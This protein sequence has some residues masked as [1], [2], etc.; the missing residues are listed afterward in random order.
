MKRI[1]RL[2]TLASAL[3]FSASML[4][5]AGMPFQANP[6][7]A[8]II[9]NSTSYTVIDMLANDVYAFDCGLDALEVTILTNGTK[10]IARVR[11]ADKK[12]EYR[13]RPNFI[14]ADQVEY[15][16][17]CPAS[18]KTASATIYINI[19]DKPDAISDAEC[20]VDPV[21]IEFKIG[22]LDKT[23]YN[24][25][26]I[27]P[28]SPIITGDIDNDGEIEI[29]VFKANTSIGSNSQIS[30]FGFRQSTQKLYLK[31][32]IPFDYSGNYPYGNIAIAKITGGTANLKTTASVFLV[33]PTTNILYRYDLNVNGA[34]NLV[35]SETWHTQYT[36]NSIYRQATPFI[37]DI[38]GNGRQQ[39]VIIDKIFDANTGT[40]LA[41]ARN[42]TTPLIPDSGESSYSF[43]RYGHNPF[44]SSVVVADIDNDGKMEIIGGDC[45]YEVNIDYNTPSNNY[46]K[47]LR[48]ANKTGH[49][50]I[51]DGGTAL[52]DFDGDGYLD[53]VVASPMQF[54][55]YG[56]RDGSPNGSV[57]VYNPRTGAVMHTN[58]INN[59]PK[60]SNPLY[61]FGPSRPF[62][63]DLDG[64]GIP[65]FAI[66]GEATLRAY[67]LNGTTLS[68]MWDLP[69]TDRSAS[70]TLS[71]FDF[72]QDGRAKLIYRDEDNLRI[73]DGRIKDENGVTIT[74]ANRVLA[75]FPGV[76]SATT[77]EYPIVADVN[78]D[79]AAEIIAVGS[80]V[81]F[82]TGTTWDHKGS[83]QVY[84]AAGE[85]KWAPARSVW[86]QLAY[87]PLYVNDDLTIPA[88]P[89]S[90]ATEFYSPDGTIDRPFNN[91][92]QQSTSLNKE[93]TMIM[94]GPDLTFDARLPKKI[95]KMD[96]TDE[97]KVDIGIV[98]QGDA[99]FTGPISLQ[100]YAYFDATDTYVAVG[101]P[102]SYPNTS[103]LS[104]VTPNNNVA[105][106][107]KI[108]NISTA[109]PAGYDN[110]FMTVNLSTPPGQT[111]AFSGSA[112][113]HGGWNN[114]VSGLS[115]VQG[116]RIICE[117]A[118]ETVYAEPK[119]TYTIKWYSQSSGGS[120]LN[121]GDSYE[122]T[123]NSDIVTYYFV[124]AYKTASSPSPISSIRDTIFVYRAP[125]SLVWTGKGN[126]KDWH[127][128]L[129]WKNP[130]TNYK[131]FTSIPRP[132]TNV[133]LPTNISNYPDLDATD[134]SDY[135]DAECSNI[136][137]EFGS[138]V[139]RPDM[140][141]YSRAFVNTTFS[142]HR[143]YMFAPPL[144]D[145]YTGDFYRNNPI[146]FYDDIKAYTKYWARRNPWKFSYTPDWT[147]L[148]YLPDQSFV[149]GQGLGVWI[150]D[151][152]ISGVTTPPRDPFD[153]AFPKQD[154]TYMV[155]KEDTPT[156][157]P[158]APIYNTPRT[159]HH[160]FIFDG[161]TA[162]ADFDLT[163]DGENKEV[164]QMVLV[165]NPF[166]AHLDFDKFYAKNSAFIQNYYCIIDE[167]AILQY[168]NKNASTLSK[169]VAPMQAFLVE[170]KAP[171][172]KLKA[173]GTMTLSVPGDK[174]RSMSADEQSTDQLSL[175]I[176]AT[177]GTE[178]AKAYILFDKDA[179]D[180]Y[181]P[182]EDISGM[183]PTKATSDTRS[184]SVYSQS[185]DKMKTLVNKLNAT[186]LKDRVIPLGAWSPK[187]SKSEDI[188]I[189]VSNLPAIPTEYEAVLYDE[190]TKE[191]FKLKY[192]SMHTFK[193]ITT[194]ADLFVEGRFSLRF[195]KSEN[196]STGI[197]QD[198]NDETDVIAFVKDN[199]L[200]L[201]SGRDIKQ[202]DVY[203]MQ[204]QLLL[205][206]NPNSS[207]KEYNLPKQDI[208]IVRISIQGKVNSYKLINQ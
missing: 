110:L 201:R 40:L 115:L 4:A 86:N 122:V 93:G 144:K 70:T 88:N 73:L 77:N 132:C 56:V 79:G 186:S 3:I 7:N 170:V 184:L 14:G 206:D 165:A 198:K 162:G 11:A 121:I 133:L 125:D 32:N 45:V 136:H 48:R 107:Y 105:L 173:N 123:K 205:N 62:V 80:V 71:M 22:L 179:D 23:D 196:N 168:Y 16:I 8:F 181:V 118:T 143:W 167:N 50:E 149:A 127:D 81:K 153:F 154:L 2:F 151:K 96:A 20:Y 6:D 60:N 106:S 46:Y 90:P 53:V 69:T 51:A 185:S 98:N 78:G 158:M 39:V 146:P 134:Y 207:V 120:V 43:G 65:E 13:P 199:T 38:M 129:N 47:L 61:A 191:E 113:C 9:P 24:T 156:P 177:Q 100:L 89:I 35:F 116:H 101:A 30:I 131:D 5:Q 160:R 67:K 152:S 145:F 175:V 128:Y 44:E 17:Y 76:Y 138:E 37:A 155:Y 130:D 68:Q 29:L 92:L 182:G 141:K 54:Y 99:I 180:K 25:T 114:I 66:T 36:N 109:L 91:F 166:M 202:I 75:I 140:L 34:G 97:L 15:Q 147:G 85:K 183:Y 84:A 108:P 203:N 171:F 12:I 19:N 103:G 197:E 83:L 204:G 49:P 102:Y 189:N 72:A 176:T 31:Y 87:N 190:L 27:N 157:D 187:G 150:S 57:Y 195:T 192:N 148:F 55:L 10:G 172:D 139:V 142:S 194:D 200:F 42:G 124:E 169:N 59:I 137:F 74:P 161:A 163:I 135:I 178:S 112:E 94:L 174:L 63:G 111:P 21:G 52:A 28:L 188:T 26:T 208:Y 95:T 193:N 18:N 58:V 1:R 164:G 119:D 159:N 82:A 117:D 104:N 126:S 33:N 41:T 64:D